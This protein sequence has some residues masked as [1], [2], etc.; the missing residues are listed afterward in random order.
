MKPMLAYKVNPLTELEKIKFPVMASAKLDGI[1]ALVSKSQGFLSRKLKPHPNKF[2]QRTM[3]SQRLIG[4]DGEFILG[5]PTDDPYRRTDSAIS[6]IEGEPEL[7]LW[8]FDDFLIGGGFGDRFKHVQ[9]V[10]KGRTGGQLEVVEHKLIKNL[11]DLLDY[12]MKLLKQGYEGLMYRKPDGSY[13]HGRSTMNEGLLV[14]LKRRLDAEARIISMHPRMKN[15]NEAKVNE[16]GGTS[17][18]SHKANKVA[19][20]TLGFMIVEDLKTKVQFELGTGKLTAPEAK[21]AWEQYKADPAGFCATHLAKY[22]YFPI[23]VKEKPRQPVLQGWRHPND[24]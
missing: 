3:W 8:V 6:T 7:T 13:K 23:G 9:Q 14:A 10:L 18:S 16:L 19:Q 21:A 5:D 11:D 1:R 12:E 24:T 22:R 15:N 17:R 2:V 4:L 20:D